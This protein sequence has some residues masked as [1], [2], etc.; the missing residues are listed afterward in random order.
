MLLNK[1][2]ECDN[3]LTIKQLILERIERLNIRNSNLYNLI[4]KDINKDAA[5]TMITDNN[6]RIANL[7]RN[8]RYYRKK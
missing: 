6:T 5:F 4:K 2:I 8:S 7:M 1:L 3:R